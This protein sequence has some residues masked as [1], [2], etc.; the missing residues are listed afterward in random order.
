MAVP[1][2]GRRGRRHFLQGLHGLFRPVFLNKTD[3]GIDDHNHNDGNRIG[4]ISDEAGN[5]GGGNQDQ[6][7]E[8]PE[9]IQEHPERGFPLL[10]DQLVRTV[11][12]QSCR[13]FPGGQS[14]G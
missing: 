11:L 10:F 4:E 8:V 12:F 1:Q 2:N 5:N 13:S 3:H 14:P 9:L 7:H 6:N